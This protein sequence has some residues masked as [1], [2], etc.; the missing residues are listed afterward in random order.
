MTPVASLLRFAQARQQLVKNVVLEDNTVRITPWKDPVTNRWFPDPSFV[1][2]DLHGQTFYVKN[3]T[4]AR[5]F[6]SGKEITALQRNAADFSNRESV[7][8][9]DTHCP[10][11]IL[12]EVDFFETNGRLQPDGASYYFQQRHAYS[13][14]YAAEVQ[15]ERDGKGTVCWKPYLANNHETS[16]LRFAYKKTNPKSRVIVGWS[17]EGETPQFIATDGNRN[18]LQGWEIPCHE[19]TDYH[20]VVVSYA[21]MLAPSDGKSKVIPRGRVK[22]FYIGLVG[23][24]GDSIFFDKIEFLSPRGLRPHSGDGLLVGGRIHPPRDG[25]PVRLNLMGEVREAI[26]DRGGWY[27]FHNVPAGAIAEITFQRAGM[28]YWPARGRLAQIEKNDVEHHIFA[29]D[30]RSPS[31]P[32][33]E[34]GQ[35]KVPKTLGPQTVSA[36]EPLHGNTYQPHSR[37]FYANNIDSKVGYLV[38]DWVNN[39]GWMDKDRRTENP[40]GSLR[41][42]LSGAC[43][44]EGAQTPVR[45][46]LNIVLESML[47]RR[48]GINV[49]VAVAS[50]SNSSIAANSYLY[51]K[52]GRSLKPDFVVL[53]N[54]PVHMWHLEPTLMEKYVGWTR[55]HSPYRSFDFDDNGRLVEFPPD[56]G[57]AVFAKKVD[58]KPLVDNLHISWTYS[59]LSEYPPAVEKSFQLFQAIAHER[60][61]KDLET[62]GGRLIVASGSFANDYPYRDQTVGTG[63]NQLSAGK[64]FQEMRRVTESAGGLFVDLS[65]PVLRFDF[66]EIMS[67]GNV[68][69]HLTPTGH[70]LIAK[71]LADRLLELP[72][73]Q[74]AIQRKRKVST[75]V[76]EK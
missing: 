65:A 63:K 15:L 26:T 28:T 51:E 10:T 46:H 29:L 59:L 72:E 60:F 1:S 23:E 55:G 47:R 50:H 54:E 62:H 25:E 8:I 14:K 27:F 69:G 40:D 71:A 68:D 74:E 56:P 53:M 22:N 17:Q 2:Q 12:D 20:E 6:V 61:V 70:Y 66:G 3:A 76:P 5:V 52:Y 30:P 57:Y 42:F 34:F 32:R 9:V 49:E 37:R 39:R 36:T 64:Y 18:G 73:F 31:I 44:E 11:V 38:E 16:H 21:D 41:L 48:T 24:K 13:G 43:L 35:Q 45:D 75:A 19:D 58:W 33:P 67:Y 4:S 7:T